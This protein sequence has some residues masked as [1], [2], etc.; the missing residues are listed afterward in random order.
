MFKGLP[1]YLHKQSLLGIH[2]HSFT[3]RNTEKLCIKLANV[4]QKSTIAGVHLSRSI[5]LRIIV[6]ID[7]PSLRGNLGNSISTASKQ[8]PKSLGSIGTSRKATT[9]T[10]DSNWLRS[11]L[12]LRII[13]QLRYTLTRHKIFTQALDTG[14]IIE[15]GRCKL[16][17][18]PLLKLTGQSHRIYRL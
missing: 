16:A 3:R 7:I 6:G 12:W 15:Q 14:I 17:S 4:L 13:L 5:R 10:N 8:L 18:H 9:H 11:N 2:S 1:R